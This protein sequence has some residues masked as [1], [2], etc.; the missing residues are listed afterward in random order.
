[1]DNLSDQVTGVEHGL[2]DIREN[3][4]IFWRKS[5]E[6]KDAQN[7]LSKNLELE[8]QYQRGI[9]TENS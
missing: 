1:M 3:I 9:Q 4:K 2:N 5:N 7:I 8:K 6:I